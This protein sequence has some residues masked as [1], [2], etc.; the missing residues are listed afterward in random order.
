MAVSVGSLVMD[1][2]AS[3]TGLSRDTAKAV[4]AGRKLGNKIALGIAAGASVAGTLLAREFTSFQKAFAE[5]KTIT[6]GTTKELRLLELQTISLADKLGTDLVDSTKG[7]YQTISASI[8]KDNAISFLE[9]A[10]KAAVGGVTEIKIAVDGLSTIVNA[11]SIDAA[12]TEEI[13]DAMFVAVRNGKTTFEELASTIAEVAPMASSLGVN[14]KEV[15]AA[16]ATMTKQGTPTA[17]AMTQ[18]RASLVALSKPTDEMARLFKRLHV[19]NGQQLLDSYGLVGALQ[20]LNSVASMPELVKA[21]GR[22]EGSNAVLQLSGKNAKL[23]TKDMADMS[24]AAGSTEAAFQLMQDTVSGFIGHVKASIYGSVFPLVQAAY[25]ELVTQ[26]GGVNNLVDNTRESITNMV[27]VLAKGFAYVGNVMAG[28]EV[29]IKTGRVA[30]ALLF[31]GILNGVNFVVSSLV[32]LNK[33]IADTVNVAIDGANALH[34]LLPGAGGDLIKRVST[35]AADSVKA[36]MQ[37]MADGA[38]QARKEIVA[39]LAAVFDGGPLPTEQVDKWI[40]DIRT[41]AANAAASITSTGAAMRSTFNAPLIPEEIV[42]DAE[43]KM[44][45]LGA[46]VEK[47][48]I[49]PIQLFGEAVNSEIGALVRG[50][51]TAN[52]AL[53][54]IANTI[55]TTVIQSL[56]TMGAEAL[57]SQVATMMGVKAAA[58]ASAAASAATAA[59][60]GGSALASWSSAAI[61]ASIATMGAAAGVGLSAYLGATATGA[62]VTTGIN[63]AS[64]LATSALGMGKKDGGPVNAGTTYP[65]HEQGI[66]EFFRPD[67]SGTVIPLADMPASSGGGGVTI[68]VSQTFTGGVTEAD[69]ARNSGKTKKET[70]DAILEAMARGGNFRKKMQA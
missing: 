3:T 6:H 65:I 52:D 10:S 53:L 70:I 18:I 28:W 55:V 57:A 25:T 12:K 15:L 47:N 58:A 2:R 21:F 27:Y 61:A 33:K 42:A 51:E 11:W 22:I 14:F 37:A 30:F 8:P 69:L 50:T 23:F 17:V 45:K 40:E 59:A 24:N 56:V 38:T 19:E 68:N 34:S 46:I 29:I 66:P 26:S 44:S 54:N 1:L 48:M 60:A 64:S 9:T 67:V 62:A 4:Q 43:S 16:I 39:E 5:V 63:A 35:D 13:A 32:D 41:Q 20:K 31:E 49:H 36:S 7:L